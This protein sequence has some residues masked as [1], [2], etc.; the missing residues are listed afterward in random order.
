M[1][2]DLALARNLE[3]ILRAVLTDDVTAEIKNEAFDCVLSL[4]GV[5]MPSTGNAVVDRL[6]KSQYNIIADYVKEGKK[7]QAIKE[8][9]TISGLGLKESK[10]I[11]E[12]PSLFP[13]P[14]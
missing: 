6:T 14:Q 11:V 9:R 7:I 1:E 8:L 4:N 13:Q 10:D 3:R 5:K 2:I 12:N